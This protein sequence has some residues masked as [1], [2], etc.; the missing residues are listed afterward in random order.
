MDAEKS[1]IINCLEFIPSPDNDTLADIVEMAKPLEATRN[2]VVGSTAV[3]LD[4]ERSMC[5]TRECNSGNYRFQKRFFFD[6]MLV[7][8]FYSQLATN[9]VMLSRLVNISTLCQTQGL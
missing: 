7:L 5:R 2:L 4:G 6:V 1:N 3:I 8:R 9:K